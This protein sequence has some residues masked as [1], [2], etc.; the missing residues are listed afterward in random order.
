MEIQKDEDDWHE[1]A[2]VRDSLAYTA[3][4]LDPKHKYR[5]RVRAVNIHGPS[6]PSEES[7]SVMMEPQE[8]KK[9]LGPGQTWSFRPRLGF[10]SRPD[11][12]I[13]FHTILTEVFIVNAS[14]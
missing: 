5:F 1:L 14:P 12:T 7:V 13:L 9:H 4:D 11:S 6:R 2:V 10:S 8:G 3:K